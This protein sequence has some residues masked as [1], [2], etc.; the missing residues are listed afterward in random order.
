LEVSQSAIHNPNDT[1]VLLFNG[2]FGQDSS[3][4]SRLFNAV[5]SRGELLP[6]SPPG[7]LQNASYSL[8]LTIPI[9][10]CLPSNDLVRSWTTAAAYKALEL[11]QFHF[12]VADANNLTWTWT[13]KADGTS[14]ST[15][16]E[17]ENNITEGGRMF[18]YSMLGNTSY[19]GTGEIK[20]KSDLWVAIANG[21]DTSFFTCT[22]QNASIPTDITFVNSIPSLQAGQMSKIDMIQ[23]GEG[24]DGYFSDSAVAYHGFGTILFNHLLGSILMADE[25][26]FWN[27]TVDQTVFANAADVYAISLEWYDNENNDFAATIDLNAT[28]WTP[29]MLGLT[30]QNKNLSALIEEVALNASLSLLSNAAFW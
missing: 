18:Y 29:Q 21:P 13:T 24:E 8:E 26:A 17:T 11:G 27:T 22:I 12:S 7:G 10:S 30:P 28:G 23:D 14:T 4:L 19:I 3:Q 16:T 15:G 20:I 2:F 25:Y 1:N 9:V 6:P 5:T